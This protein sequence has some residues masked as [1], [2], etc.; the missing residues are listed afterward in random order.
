MLHTI[1][2]I[3]GRRSTGEPTSRADDVNAQLRAL[4]AQFYSQFDVPGPL[5]EEENQDTDRRKKHKEEGDDNSASDDDRQDSLSLNDNAESIMEDQTSEDEENNY[6]EMN[7]DNDEFDDDENLLE[8]AQSTESSVSALQTSTRR[9]PETVVFTDPSAH[10]SYT[11]PTKTVR[12]Q[13]M[14]CV[15]LY[16]FFAA[17]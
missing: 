9:V 7:E 2:L 15:C 11:Q 6:D 3:M 14:V 5:R 17:Q 16:F 13:F 10:A 8:S 1:F 12:K 4:E